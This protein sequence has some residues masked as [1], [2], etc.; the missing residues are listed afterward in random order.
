ML[1]EGLGFPEGPVAMGDGSVIFVEIRAGRLSRVDRQGSLSV[2]A[3]VGGGPNGAAVG[4]DGAVYVCNNGGFSRRNRAVPSI[5]RVDLSTGDA[6][7]VY[8]GLDDRPLKSPNDLVFDSVG[9]FWFTDFADGAIYYATPDGGSLT[10]ALEGLNGPNG[11]GL[12]PGGDVLYWAE[13]Y[14]RQ[15]H[16]RRLSAPGVMVDSPPFDVQSLMRGLTLDRWTV[17][18]GLPGVE[19]LDS[20]AVEA[21]GRCASAPSSTAASPWCTPATAR[22]SATPCR[23]RSTTAL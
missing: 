9:N 1:A 12:S 16:R 21:G 19:E 14:T 10:L 11:I 8:T 17:V 22:T 18:A 13:T 15:V 6:R 2:V 4:P 3:E 23:V 5:Q 20:L 7:T